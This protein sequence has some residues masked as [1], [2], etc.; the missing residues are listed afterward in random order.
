MKRK[1]RFARRKTKI[2]SK[3]IVTSLAILVLMVSSTGTLFAQS[4]Q[5]QIDALDRQIDQ[6]QG[7]LNGIS[8]RGDTLQNKLDGINAEIAAI[9]ARIEKANLEISQT[10]VQIEETKVKLDKQK[11]IMYENAK[12]LYKEGDVSTLE[13]LASSNNFSEFVNRQEYLEKVKENVNK[14]AREVITLKTSLEANLEKLKN[15]IAESNLQRAVQSTKQDEQA[16]LVAQTRGEEAAYQRVVSAD[17]SRVEELRRQQAAIISASQ[18]NV[19][20]GGSGGYPWANAPW[21]N[22]L[23]DSWGMYQRQCVSYTAWKVAS[24]GRYMPY[25]GGYGNANQWD[26]NA[27]SSGI[28]TGSNPVVDSVAISNSGAYG[29]SMYV[30]AVLGGGMIRVSQYNAGWTGTYSLADVSSAGL[31]FIYF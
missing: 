13:V 30:E 8:A 25:W 9:D 10:N 22:E 6:Q 24:T 2:T 23:A 14:A 15:V 19:V 17:R 31:V 5:D 28:P 29:H 1:A 20:S 26:D 16:N 11:K 18:S 3:I 7:V 21:P 27:R 4:L 12:A